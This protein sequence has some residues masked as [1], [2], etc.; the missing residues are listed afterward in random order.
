LNPAAGPEAKLRGDGGQARVPA[1]G[2]VFDQETLEVE[3][4]RAGFAFPAGDLLPE[5]AGLNL[6]GPG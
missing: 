3:H 5:R 6:R 2:G 4:Q 1:G